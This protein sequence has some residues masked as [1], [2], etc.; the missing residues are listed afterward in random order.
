ML[1]RRVVTILGLS[2]GLFG[3]TAAP[4][5]AYTPTDSA[6]QACGAFDMGDGTAWVPPANRAKLY[7]RAVTSRG[8][9]AINCGDGSSEGAVHIEVKHPLPNWNDGLN[10]IQKTISKGSTGTNGT[11]TNYYRKFGGITMVVVTGSGKV[12]TVYPT[13]RSTTGSGSGWYDC[14]RG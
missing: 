14:S 10:C 9:F 3:A 4:A 12:I 8:N 13:G 5:M 7:L 11:K 6:Q 1:T 2:V